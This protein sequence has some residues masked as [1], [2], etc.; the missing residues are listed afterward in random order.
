MDDDKGERFRLAEELVELRLLAAQ[1]KV[2]FGA[3]GKGAGPS[4][5]RYES[6]RESAL[7]ADVRPA[8]D[9]RPSEGG[10]VGR[11]PRPA[12]HAEYRHD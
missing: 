9:Q 5:C 7:V 6:G 4:T 12:V 10:L 1:D 3:E 8:P 11:R 2:G